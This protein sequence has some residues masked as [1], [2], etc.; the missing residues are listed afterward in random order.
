[1]GSL[2]WH[3]TVVLHQ[4]SRENLGLRAVVTY[5]AGATLIISAD[6]AVYDLVM[7]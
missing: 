5:E 6:G 3:T 2:Y 1:M 7:W 4:R